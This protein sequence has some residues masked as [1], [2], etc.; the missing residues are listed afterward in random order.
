M[1]KIS[2]KCFFLL[3]LDQKFHIFLRKL[4][5][6][7][8]HSEKTYLAEICATFLTRGGPDMSRILPFCRGFLEHLELTLT[9]ETSQVVSLD[10]Y[11]PIQ[12][13][14]RS[15]KGHPVNF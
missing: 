1:T 15:K 5:G 12:R 11:L 14:K 2:R 3:I 8:K 10:Y 6:F 7:F 9:N 4:E 13:K